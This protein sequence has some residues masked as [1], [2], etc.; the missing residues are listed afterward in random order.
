MVAKANCSLDAH[1]VTSDLAN[2]LGIRRLLYW[3]N[4]LQKRGTHRNR[5]LCIW[6]EAVDMEKMGLRDYE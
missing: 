1:S 2:R 5:G 6:G 4:R 3:V